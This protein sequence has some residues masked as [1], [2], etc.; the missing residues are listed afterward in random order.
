MSAFFLKNSL[1]KPFTMAR[2]RATHHRGIAALG[3]VHRRNPA[4]FSSSRVHCSKSKPHKT[5]SN[6]KQEGCVSDDDP[7]PVCPGSQHNWGQFNANR[8]NNNVIE[9]SKDSKNKETTTNG[10]NPKTRLTVFR[11]MSFLMT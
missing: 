10:I 11:T 2:Q 7:C 8:D 9:T 6:K 3:N 5:K 1:S 4:I